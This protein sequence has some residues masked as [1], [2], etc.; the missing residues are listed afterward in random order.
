[1]EVSALRIMKYLLFDFYRFEYD[2]RKW[3]KENKAFYG[4]IVKEI[5]KMPQSDI[6]CTTSLEDMTY[7]VFDLET[8]G[9]YSTLGDEVVSLGAVKINMNDIQFPE[10]FYEIISPIKRVPKEI[11]MLTGLSREEINHSGQP[12]P[13]SFKKFLEFSYETVVV[14]HPSSFDVNFLKELCKKWELP[15][16]RPQ[17]IDSYEVANFLYPGERNQIDDLIKRFDIDKRERHHALNDA[18]MTAEVFEKLITK[19]KERNIHTLED[20]LT[21]R[22]RRKD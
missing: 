7:T 11:L 1:M 12:F 9:L 20:W 19:L 17:S 4:E 21:V 18:Y 3:L 6:D 14:A 10:Q 8:T 22:K 13:Y 5:Q 16:Y 15:D 2:K